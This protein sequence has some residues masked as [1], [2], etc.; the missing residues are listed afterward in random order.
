MRLL[1]VGGGYETNP[2]QGA[3]IRGE[4][5]VRST[6]WTKSVKMMNALL[7]QRVQPSEDCPV[8]WLFTCRS[9]DLPGYIE[10]MHVF[11]AR[12]CR[13][14]RAAI[15][16]I[17][18]T[19]QTLAIE[20]RQSRFCNYF[21]CAVVH[22]SA[23]AITYF[24]HEQVSSIDPSQNVVGRALCSLASSSSNF[25]FSPFFAQFQRGLP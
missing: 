16:H 10:R 12:S 7:Q 2:R 22:V 23:T 4:R 21:C 9:R 14:V 5:R 13:S 11:L 24:L 6:F 18:A 3:L 19:C 17:D 15:Y 8:L 1:G 20:I 25:P